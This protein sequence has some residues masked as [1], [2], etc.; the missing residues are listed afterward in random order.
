MILSLENSSS[1]LATQ[2]MEFRSQHKE[3]WNELIDME[4]PAARTK[5]NNHGYGSDVSLV[6][7]LSLLRSHDSYPIFAFD[8]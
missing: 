3:L 7:T 6:F 4:R 8:H 1:R 5:R 2:M